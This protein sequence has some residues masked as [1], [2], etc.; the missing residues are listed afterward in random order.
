MRNV[1]AMLK[2]VAVRAKNFKVLYAVVAPVPV[3]VMDAKDF[4]VS[5]I[6]ASLT[7]LDHVPN[8]HLLANSR[9]LCLKS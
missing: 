7:C 3:L 2:R 8:K 5:V 6:P 4:R 1:L 9:K